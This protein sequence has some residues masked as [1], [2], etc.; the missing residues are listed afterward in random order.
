MGDT[1]TK[2]EQRALLERR[3][4]RSSSCS[5]RR[6]RERRTSR[7]HTRYRYGDRLRR[8]LGSVALTAAVYARL[9]LFCSFCPSCIHFSFFGEVLRR[10]LETTPNIGSY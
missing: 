5:T 9:C 2:R 3:E 1:L 6:S 7:K 4:T 8:A 10:P